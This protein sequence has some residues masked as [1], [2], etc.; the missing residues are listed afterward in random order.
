MKDMSGHEVLKE[1]LQRA[2][3]FVRSS[4]LKPWASAVFQSCSTIR[5]CWSFIRI[6]A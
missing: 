5:S 2:S 1:E 4:D 3:F 6:L